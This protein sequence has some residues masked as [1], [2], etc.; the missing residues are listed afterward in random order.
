MAYNEKETYMS[1]GEK[2]T[3]SSIFFLFGRSPDATPHS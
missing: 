2:P 3:L 1:Y